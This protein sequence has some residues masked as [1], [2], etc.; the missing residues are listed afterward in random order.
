MSR[1]LI[2]L[3]IVIG[4][5]L[6]LGYVVAV[7]LRKRN[8]ALLASL[9]ERKEELYNLPVNDEVEAVKNMHLIGQ[10][11][12]A[13]REWNQKWVDLSLNSF[14]DIEN[15]LFEAEGY[16]NSFR[17]LKAK[18]AIGNIESQVQLIDEDIK[19]I[20]QA[21]SE[22]KEKEEMN[23]G[24]VVHA[25]DM[26]EN[27]QKQVA[28]DPDAYGPALPEIEKQA[29]NIQVEFSKFV[30]LNSSGDPVEAAEILD[31]AENHIVALTHIVEKVPAIVKDL[32]TTLPDQL[33]DLES[34]YRKLLESGYHF[35]ETDLEARF[36]QLH[37][38][39]KANLANVA[40]LELDN[41]L[42]ENEQIQEEI[43]ALYDIFTREIESH[44]VVEKLV[45]ALPGYL[46][47]AKENNKSLA[48][49][50]E[51]LS[52]I[53]ESKVLKE[54]HLKELEAELTAQELVVEDA[55]KDTSETQK[56]YSILKEE[57][58]AIEAR[59]KEIEDEQI[60][61]NDSLSK[62]EKDD[63][64]ARQKANIY[65]NRL[66]AIKR[67]MDKRN[68]PGIPQEF[69]ELFFTA[70]NNTEALMDELEGDKINIESTNRL[71]EILTNDMN[72]LEEA[73]YRIVQNATLT[74]QLLQYS[75]RYRSFDDHVQAAFDESL[76]IF[77]REYDYAASFKVISDALE[78]VEAG[79]TD[80]FVTSYEKT[81][82]QIHF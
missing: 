75:N 81:R 32:Q 11:Q 24:R 36:Q 5:L 49:E 71:L 31:T 59:L 79:V 73:A 39:L 40:A 21:L 45:K 35:T 64:N 63:A 22:L 33:E 4:V 17:F 12:V 47:H 2:I 37:A 51:R 65:A 20:R 34:G 14:A 60:N 28:S 41:A 76:Y 10:S 58:E 26:F 56:A 1:G 46:A 19:A 27:L 15:N 43:N 70:S 57:L 78:M 44:K 68:L 77:E 69:L 62:I 38:A 55:L 72:E 30:T 23:S 6:V 9:E 18:Q 48:E 80:R 8:E 67:Y 29:E 82:E 53:F 16:N 61:L 54:N 25:L 66:H 7:L 13:F 42:Y 74:E 3:I 50:V 52:K